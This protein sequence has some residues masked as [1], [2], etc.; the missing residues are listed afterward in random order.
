MKFTRTFSRL[1]IPGCLLM[2]ALASV[3]CKQKAEDDPCDKIGCCGHGTCSAA[4]GSAR[5]TCED[6]YQV[7][8]DGLRCLPPDPGLCAGQTCSEH[9]C[10]ELENGNPICIC[11]PDFRVD[12][13]DPLKLTCI[14]KVCLRMGEKCSDSSECCDNDCLKYTGQKEGYCTR[15]NCKTNEDCTNRS[16]DG[17]E[18]CCI[19]VGGE[20][21]ICM[22]L[23][24]GCFCGNQTGSCGASCT[25]QNDS[26]CSP[27]FSCLRGSDEDS[28][29]ICTKPCLTDQDCRDCRN[30]QDP[31][32]LYICQPI[33]GGETYC[34]AAEQPTCEWSG[35]CGGN[36]VCIAYPTADEKSLE[37]RCNQLGGLPTGT[38]CDDGANPNQLPFEERCADFYCMRGFCSEVCQLDTDC[39]EHMFCGEVRFRMD[40]A[41]D[42]SAA[43]GMCQGGTFCTSG[44]DCE[45]QDVCQVAQISVDDLV[46]M[47]GQHDGL[48]EVGEACDDSTSPY[49]LPPDQACRGFYCM[50]GNCTEVCVED[51]DCVNAGR[52]CSVTFGGMGE[53]GND[54][55]SIGLCRWSPGSGQQCAGNDDCPAHETCQYC[56]KEGESIDKF[57]QAEN[58]DVANSKCDPPGT[59]GCGDDGA[60]ACWGDLCLVTMN[61]SFCSSL[62]DSNDDCPGTMS[63]GLM[64]VTDTQTTGVCTP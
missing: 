60:N 31:N 14:E 1:I 58:C 10:C 26:A 17:K 29:A 21:F 63:C 32:M 25:C 6:G 49:D 15:R 7:S 35:D 52:C 5:C 41:G 47:C 61:S 16:K 28:G 36:D 37:G 9:G 4:S 18:M 38:E 45:G 53:T 34:L 40:D 48:L 59:D 54:T 44:A 50:F 8:T 11:D 64:G 51:S 22:K 3:G 42:V 24:S 20:Y 46:G 23:G 13:D 39:P 19:D 55:A 33:F 2:L 57:C 62:C 27:G 43:I 12:P 30:V 56:V